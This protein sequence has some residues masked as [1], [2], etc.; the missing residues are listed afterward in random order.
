MPIVSNKPLQILVR[1][2]NWLGDLVMA[3]PLLESLKKK[4]PN[5]ILT[6]SCIKHFSEILLHHPYIDHIIPLERSSGLRE[7]IFPKKNV[8]NLRLKQYDLG[9]LT[10][11][12]LSSAWIFFLSNIKKIVGFNSNARGLLLTCK[13]PFPKKRT[14]QHLVKTYKSLLVPIGI[15]IDDTHPLITTIPKEDEAALNLLESQGRDPKQT[16]IGINPGAAYGQAKCWPPEYFIS[17]SQKLIEKKD[18]CIVFF[19]DKLGKSLIDSI[20][21]KLPK[22]RVINLAGKT[23][24]RELVCLIKQCNVFLTNDSGPMHIAAALS[25]PLIALF[26]STSDTLTGPYPNGQVIH[27]H[28]S[29]SPC[30]LRICPIDFR[31]MKQI[32]VEEVY[33]ALEAKLTN[34]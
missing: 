25:T 7:K 22:E 9:V 24:I 27:K 17:L 2:P 14:S 15:P 12:S 31:C 11:N 29:C 8:S 28:T 4:W 20:C 3:T 26:G 16:L 34:Y 23:N 6:V 1:M 10:T 32:T 18:H 13:V 19:G 33:E 21:S 5:S 30:F